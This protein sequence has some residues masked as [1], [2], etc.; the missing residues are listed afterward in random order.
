[1]DHYSED[2]PVVKVYYRLACGTFTGDYMPPGFALIETELTRGER[3]AQEREE[4]EARRLAGGGMALE[5]LF[6]QR[7]RDGVAHQR[8]TTTS[9]MNNTKKNQKGEDETCSICL[10][11]SA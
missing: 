6:L 2:G 10:L 4:A 5:M 1:M 7:I 9:H 8:N 3:E 11:P